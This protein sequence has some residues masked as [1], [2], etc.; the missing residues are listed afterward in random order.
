MKETKKNIKIYLDRG[1][2]FCYQI[3]EYARKQHMDWQLIDYSDV[4]SDKNLW[5][6]FQRLELK[7]FPVLRID[8]KVIKFQ[9]VS[10]DALTRYLQ[11]R[12]NLVL[13]I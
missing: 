8:G 9:P 3:T 5:D 2:E 12:Q 7:R 11:Q 1:D 13:P 6:E 10:V 4:V